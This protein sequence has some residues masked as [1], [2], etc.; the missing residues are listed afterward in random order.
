MPENTTD[1]H[2]R[3]S[4]P[5]SLAH[6]I[7]IKHPTPNPQNEHIIEFTRDERI[8]RKQLI[9]GLREIASPHT[10]PRALDLFSGNGSVAEF[11]AEEGWSD[12]TGMDQY[13]PTKILVPGAKW[14]HWHLSMLALC[15]HNHYEL[16]A[17]VEKLR[18]AFDLVMMV[19]TE[20]HDYYIREQLADFFLKPKGV[21]F[22]D[23]RGMSPELIATGKWKPTARAL[24]YEKQF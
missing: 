14:I 4:N 17:D 2:D 23:Y 8:L 5:D 1:D 9:E 6:L 21:V 16:P 3:L 12:I 22:P 11:L 20:S 10:Y 15:I 24:F 18:S 7:V 13:T 19:Q